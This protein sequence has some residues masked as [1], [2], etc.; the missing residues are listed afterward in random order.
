MNEVFRLFI[1]YVIVVYFDERTFM[2][3]MN[4]VLRPFIGYVVVVYF[5]DIVITGDDTEGI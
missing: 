3:L 1:G 2:R 4:E 5:D